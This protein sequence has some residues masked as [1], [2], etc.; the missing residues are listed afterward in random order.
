MSEQAADAEP[1]SPGS[2]LADVV[3]FFGVQA[4]DDELRWRLP[5]TPNVASYLGYMHGGCGLA[6]VIAAAETWSGRPLAS[7]SAQYM[8]RVPLGGNAEITFDIGSQG[9]R[10]TQAHAQVTDAADGRLLM[11]VL[12]ALGGRR[13]GIDEDWGQP[14]EVPQPDEWQRRT[15]PDNAVPSFSTEADIRF[16]PYRAG[17]RIIRCWA[18][19]DGTLASTRAGLTAL[20]DT[21]A[22]GM[23]L[24]LGLKWRG[25][26]LDNTV[27]I[28]GDAESEWVLLEMCTGGFHNAVGHGTVR[29]YSPDGALLASGSQS[30]A[31]A[32]VGG[33]QEAFR[34]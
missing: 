16:G 23:H 15:V 6:S 29:V 8:A 27:R 11:R 20:A 33:P 18:R 7:A 30:F 9:K 5:I 21:L 3:E 22:T 32:R 12:L 28:A 26:S 10:M 1:L 17:D 4:T 24:S 25:A 34:L 14:P 31:V 13:L 19:L 2:R